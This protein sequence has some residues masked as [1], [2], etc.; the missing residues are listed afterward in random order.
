MIPEY[1]IKKIRDCYYALF[2]TQDLITS[3][4]INNFEFEQH[5][6]N[7]ISKILDLYHGGSILDIGANIGTYTINLALKHQNLKFHCFE[8]QR[9]IN[10]Q[11]TTNIFLNK[12]YNAYIYRVALSDKKGAV[13]L[14]LPDYLKES[15]IG[16]FSIDQSTRSNEY[17]C[18]S[19]GSIENIGTELLDSYSFKNV[20]FIKIDVEGHE[21][22]VFRGGTE[23]IISNGYPTILFECWTSKPWYQEKAELTKQ[24]LRDLQYVLY[25]YNSDIVAMH[26]SRFKIEKEALEEMEFWNL[27][28]LSS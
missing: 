25:S 14:T 22:D 11:L 3:S 18:H 17:E 8:P 26:P 4:I 10:Y 27:E 2:D 9:I 21:L 24:F 16:A 28:N 13:E 23:T 1:S 6:V 5:N 15:N 19:S 20:V 12:I 7:T